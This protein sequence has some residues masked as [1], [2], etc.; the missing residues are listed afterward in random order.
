MSESILRK[1]LM[2]SLKVT[3]WN[4][5]LNCK[6]SKDKKDLFDYSTMN[7]SKNFLILNKKSLIINPSQII[8]YQIYSII[9]IKFSFLVRLEKSNERKV[10]ML[11]NLNDLPFSLRNCG[12]TNLDQ[13]DPWW[14][15]AKTIPAANIPFK[16][17]NANLCIDNTQEI[18]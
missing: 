18:R 5:L 17:W 11:E 6:H 7:S 1:T 8:V 14:I 12:T 10:L 16:V 13:L 2:K 4:H 3:S 15:L 9:F